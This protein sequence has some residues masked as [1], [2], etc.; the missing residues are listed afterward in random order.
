MTRSDRDPVH[1]PRQVEAL[2]DALGEL[3]EE[4]EELRVVGADRETLERNRQQIV[5]VQWELS[6]ALIARHHHFQPA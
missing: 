4:R 6:R 1:S 5:T 2:K 3:L